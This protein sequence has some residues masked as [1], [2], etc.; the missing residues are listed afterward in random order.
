MLIS[1]RNIS[2]THGVKALFAGVCI[3]V[4]RGERIGLIGPNGAGKSTLLRILAGDELA[5]DGAII[6]E[7]GVRAV[8]VPQHDVFAPAA[9]ARAVATEAALR[10]ADEGGGRHDEHEA[11]L[12]AE[13]MLGRV[14]FD[15]ALVDA[16]TSTLSGGW[17]KRLALARA[18]ARC[19]G[20]PDV[21]LL[22]EPT[23]HLDLEG[24]RWLEEL[25]RRA[26]AGATVAS[27]FVTHDRVFLENVATRVVELGPAYPGGTLAVDGNYS[28]F[29]R[30]KEEFLSG[31]ARAEAT[32]ANQVRQD[33]AWLARGAQARRTKAKGRIES[34]FGRMDE[35]AELRG[36]NGAAVAGGARVD[37]SA[38]GRRTRKLVAAH[39]VAKALGGRTLFR[40]VDVEL[41][42]G[43][44]LGL[45]G[46]N[47]SGKTTFIR[48]LIGELAPDAGVVKQSDP[49]PRIV[50]FRQHRQDFPPSTLLRDALCPVGDQVRFLG[51]PMHVASWSRRFLFGDDQLDQ[52]VSALS[53]GEL[54]RVH[55]ARIM[56]EPAD[57]LVLDEPT[58]DLDIPTLEVLEEAI[59][60]FP[61]A[62]VLVTHDRAMLERL[63][64]EV[65]L[66]DG[67]GGPTRTFASLDHALTAQAAVDAQAEQARRRA[68]EKAAPKV[69]AAPGASTAPPR[70]GRKRLS[71]NEQ[72]DYD[73]L[74]SRIVDAEARATAAERR[75]A[76]PV[77]VAD[78]NA[79]AQACRDLEAA[80]AA[81][82]ALYARWT[83]LEAKLEG[84]SA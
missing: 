4:D 74:E 82:E 83:E 71:F 22:D 48:T 14:G 15:E 33:L 84:K 43:D 77:V 51:Q 25:L 17:R 81:V 64:T 42:P 5:D 44:R 30:R 73:T 70:S 75:L 47:G 49:P 2:K 55:I 26:Q 80:H 56:L 72:R 69:A 68:K 13:M 28:E 23:N 37:F 39:G 60:G 36:R 65:L 24:I 9:S 63:A 10:F 78:H 62:V 8:Y 27:V 3:G 79:M 53:G 41:G 12:L 40:D 46:P 29:L 59:E 31:Q 16:P 50:V 7:R 76:D 38:T 19:G 66:L 18:L 21:L 45:L 32:L 57:L 67:A 11:E 35:L 58:N 52:P 1:A 20:E 34:S 54:A 6:A 61:G